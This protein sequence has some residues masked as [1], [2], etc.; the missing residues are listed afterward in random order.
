MLESWVL[1]KIE[2]LKNEQFI[3]RAPQVFDQGTAS[4]FGEHR[5]HGFGSGCV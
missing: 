1:T 5:S 2:P 3:E 4:G